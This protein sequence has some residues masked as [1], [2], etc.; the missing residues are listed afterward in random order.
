MNIINIATYRFITLATAELPF[1]RDTLKR[2]CTELALKGTILLSTEGV[3]LFLAGTREGVD[4]FKDFLNS[5]PPFQ[6]LTYKESVSAEIPFK[7][8][9][10]KI[11]KEIIRMDM[12]DIQPEKFTAPHLSPEALKQWYDEGRDMVILDTRNTFE[13]EIGTFKNAVQVNLK[14]FRDFPAALET[15]PEEFQNKPIV[16]FCT[17]GIRCEKAAALMIKKGFKEVYQLDG[18]IL[19]YFEKCG[20]AHYEGDCFVFDDRITLNSNLDVSGD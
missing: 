15:L 4:G 19:N 3:N 7:K 18:G 13:Y 17:G 12:P 14:H 6:D 9:F 11:K 20:D 16:T 10:V 1:L 8:M 5:L 2:K